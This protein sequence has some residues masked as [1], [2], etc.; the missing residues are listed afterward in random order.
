MFLRRFMT[1]SKFN[2]MDS[3]VSKHAALFNAC[4]IQANKERSE[5]KEIEE[6]LE[7]AIYHAKE[8]GIF[9]NK[10]KLQ[11]QLKRASLDCQYGFL[12]RAMEK[13]KEALE[14]VEEKKEENLFLFGIIS[15]DL[16]QC[17]EMLGD[18]DCAEDH[19]RESIYCFVGKRDFIPKEE[20]PFQSYSPLIGEILSSPL[21][22]D[23]R[24]YLTSKTLQENENLLYNTK[25]KQEKPPFDTSKVGIYHNLQQTTK[26]EEKGNVKQRDKER[27]NESEKKSE[28]EG[29]NESEKEST[30]LSDSEK[31]ERDLMHL[32][33][34]NFA[35]LLDK[36][37]K[38]KLA[39][40]MHRSSLLLKEEFQYASNPHFHTI[41]NKPFRDPLLSHSPTTPFINY[42]SLH[43]FQQT[44]QLEHFQQQIIDLSST[45]ERMRNNMGRFHR[46][47]VSYLLQIGFLRSC[48]GQFE[49]AEDYY[50]QAISI[51]SRVFGSQSVQVA[52]IVVALAHLF[53]RRGQNK[54]ALE[55]MEK[56]FE[57]KRKVLG[58]SHLHVGL[59][60]FEVGRLY[61]AT[62][63]KA[64]ASV[65]AMQDALSLFD[66]HL[67]NQ[68]PWHKMTEQV[69]ELSRNKM[70]EK[71]EELIESLKQNK[72]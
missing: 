2:Q 45:L 57:M 4:L 68:H 62:N 25:R 36:Q 7:K 10:T 72:K 19:L 51:E 23:K 32:S 17:A 39:L 6:L 38:H 24:K 63:T 1:S 50:Q 64:E 44:W 41:L 46:S 53:E 9:D 22:K 5:H 55:F 42:L 37:K 66:F 14:M 65:H 27:E 70:N 26:T 13:Y 29:E 33:C 34:S 35:E 16:S 67:S 54:L 43:P 18:L 11:I 8:A 12:S 30:Q 71:G 28:S 31:Y 3:K 20:T 48:C 21:F 15:S 69:L 58:S 52:N 47:L 60:N 56:A 61:C 40:A 49:A 59:V